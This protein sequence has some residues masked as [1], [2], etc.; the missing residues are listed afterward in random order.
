MIFRVSALHGLI[1]ALVFAEELVS[2]HKVEQTVSHEAAMLADVFYDLKRY[3]D[4]GT[5]AMRVDLAHYVG[6]VID[7]EWGRLATDRR[8]SDQAWQRWSLLYEGILD[9]EP[10]TVRQRALKPVLLEL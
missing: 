9:L 10:E 7:V 1:L 6:T 2:R 8:L 3:D 5:R 4:P